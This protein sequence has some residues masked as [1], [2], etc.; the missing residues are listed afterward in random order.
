[1][2]EFSREAMALRLIDMLGCA[3]RELAMRHAVYPKMVER[4]RM[5]A[6]EAE[7]ET[8]LMQAIV[9]HLEQ[10]IVGYQPTPKPTVRDLLDEPPRAGKSAGGHAR[11][12]SLTPERRSEIASQAA[13]ARWNDQ[14]ED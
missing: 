2:A 4:G 6:A 10:E 7:R 14:P 12:A 11:A 13:Q 1:M 8:C 5:R 3:R 9:E